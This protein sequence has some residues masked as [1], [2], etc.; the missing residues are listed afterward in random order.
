MSTLYAIYLAIMGLIAV[1][2]LFSSA[3]SRA[4]DNSEVER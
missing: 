2:D 3:D 4:T 1:D